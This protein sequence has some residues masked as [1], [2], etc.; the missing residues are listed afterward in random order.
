MAKNNPVTNEMKAG[1]GKSAIGL[2]I[3]AVLC[4]AVVAAAVIFLINNPD[5]MK[6]VV[7]V[8]LL[9]VVVIVII[10][11]IIAVAMFVLAIPMYAIRGERYQKDVAYDMDDVESVESKKDKNR[12]AH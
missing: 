5:V 7:K 4:V 10:A 2:L 3:V 9:I 6:D 11:I 1:T 12:G 8:I